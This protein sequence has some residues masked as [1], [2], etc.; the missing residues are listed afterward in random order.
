[1]LLLATVPAWGQQISIWPGM[2]TSPTLPLSSVGQITTVAVD[3]NGMLYLANNSS[4]FKI[5]VHGNTST[6]KITGLNQVGGLAIDAG[7]NMYVSDSIGNSVQRVDAATKAVTTVPTTALNHPLGL[8]LDSAG[9]LY[10]ADSANSRVVEVPWTGGAWG[11]QIPVADNTTLSAPAG[12]AFDSKG[13]LYIADEGTGT[14]TKLNLSNGNSTLVA[15]AQNGALADGTPAVSANIGSP[16]AVFVD[17]ASNVYID[18][19]VQSGGPGLNAIRKIDASNGNIYTI[20][21]GGLVA[22]TNNGTVLATGAQLPNI[23]SFGFD[24][25]GTLYIASNGTLSAVSSSLE[26]LIF[27]PTSS[28]QSQTLTVS[29]VGT[30]P[31]QFSGLALSNGQSTFTLGSGLATDCTSSTVLSPA[32]SCSLRISVASRPTGLT[33]GSL[34]LSDNNVNGSPQTI[35][36]IAGPALANLAFSISPIISGNSYE[37]SVTAIDQLGNVFNYTGPL[38]VSYGQGQSATVSM[39]NGSGTFSLPGLG[40]GPVNLSAT[41]NGVTGTASFSFPVSLTYV[42]SIADVTANPATGVPQQISVQVLSAGSTATNFGGTVT[43]SS[44]DPAVPSQAYTFSASDSGAHTFTITFGNP[45]L[46]TITASIAGQ[47]LA[48]QTLQVQGLP[49]V[50]MRFFPITPCR[51]VDT[52]NAN[53]ALGGPQMPA[54]SSRPFSLSTSPCG[55]PANAAAYS[56]NITAVPDGELGYLAIWPNGQA[57]PVV[58]TLNSDGR[59]KANAAIVPAGINAPG[60]N[61]YVSH[62]SHVVIDANGYFL[63]ADTTTEGLNFHPVTPCRIADTRNAAGT[64]GGPYLTGGQARSFPIAGSCGIPATA[65]AYSLNFTAIPHGILGFL[66]AWPTSE[67]QPVVSTLNSSTGTVTANAAIVP[68]GN[69]GGPISVFASQDADV[70]IDINGYFDDPSTGGL[71]LYVMSPC[72]IIDTREPAGTQPFDGAMTVNVVGS[73]CNVPSYAQAYVLNATVVPPDPFNFLTLWPSDQNKPWVSTLNAADGAV[74][75]NMAIVPASSGGL[76]N[77]FAS[78]PVQ[79]I[80]DI[81]SYFAP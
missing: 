52:R 25:T 73:T 21:G 32:A 47:G 62:P 6:T 71:L 12:L 11:L 14:V 24:S 79:L 1:M 34:V 22:I 28:V 50:G 36:L 59:P 31:L 10:I 57:Q 4:V 35:N 64:F 78:D 54:N 39:T 61:V 55:I 46:Q 2:L 27:P 18:A 16:N 74:S 23:S 80:L 56:L 69:P 63:P 68:A 8:A 5:D 13:Y 45:G 51:V 65:K 29:N 76:I 20:A 66:S 38:T 40:S 37:F 72:R 75:S 70:V 30:A 44:S 41:L 67:S 3:Q 15:G 53:G 49:T 9:N 26:S 7:G 42:P 33:V 43:L 48:T 19:Q 77:A 17:A 58:S 60:I 81:S